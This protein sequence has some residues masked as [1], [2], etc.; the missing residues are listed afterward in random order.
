MGERVASRIGDEELR[1][2][3]EVVGLG[4]QWTEKIVSET[5]HTL[6][7]AWSGD[8]RTEAEARFPALAEHYLRRLDS[9]PI[10][11]VT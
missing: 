5:V 4:A 7:V 11:L 10:C 1:R 8:L 2:L 3:A 6:R 9:L